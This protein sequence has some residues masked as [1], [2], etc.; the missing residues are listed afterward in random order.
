[1]KKDIL[2][3]F[4]RKNKNYIWMLLV[5][6]L[7]IVMLGVCFDFYY[8]LNDDVVMKN[9]MSGSYSGTPDG[10][11]MQTLYILGWFISLFYKMS[12][13]LPWYGLFLCLCQF[14]SVYLISIRILDL[15][16]ARTARICYYFIFTAF[17]WGMGLSHFVIVQYSI[18]CGS[19]VAVAIF[20]FITTRGGLTGREFVINNIPAIVLVVLAFQ[21]RTEMVLLLSPFIAL[22]GLFR[23]MEEERFFTVENYKKYG[24]VLGIMVA[25]MLLSCVI[26]LPAY[27]N[28]SWSDFRR[29]F[30]NRTIVYDYY[31]EMITDEDKAE[32]LTSVGVSDVQR[33]LLRNYNFGLDNTI[34]TKLMDTV[35]MVAEVEHNAEGNVFGRMVTCFR[36]MCYRLTHK[37][38]LP[39]NIVI[40]LLYLHLLSL[41]IIEYFQRKR[42]RDNLEKIGC[43]EGV[44]IPAAQRFD[45]IK[46]I[47]QIFMAAIIRTIPWMYVLLINRAPERI[48][49]GL[50]LS[51]MGLVLGAL[52]RRI[53]RFNEHNSVIAAIKLGTSFDKRK[54]S[55]K[56]WLHE[57]RAVIFNHFSLLV[58]V[59]FMI[60]AVPI[61]IKNMR[62]LN[63][64][65]EKTQEVS[66]ALKEY[67]D[68]HPQYF[69]FEDVYSTVS[70]S[71][72]MFKGVDNT[73]ANYDIMG[74]WICKS[75]LYQDKLRRYGLKNTADGLLQNNAF[76]VISNEQNTDGFKWLTD[77]YNGI[78]QPVTV[79]WVEEITDGYSVYKVKE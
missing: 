53:I 77:Y 2:I 28:S 79:E 38:D 22:A 37:A 76:L 40:V 5:L 33:E 42:Q 11:N 32:L 25:G 7:N 39:Y 17:C 43:Y 71:E 21:L 58:L 26:D 54:V 9:I 36:D 51:E 4:Y 67:Y 30:D 70:F 52:I 55:V 61:S 1:M 72:K 64:Y 74:G 44:S 66:L 50:Y 60:V 41:N 15:L 8:D 56:E 19:M 35:V 45:R 29:F 73:L 20:W 57:Y 75:P 16:K 65:R 78:G 6:I 47:L 63:E 13:G 34:N 59:V 48:T 18:A 3:A 46:Y 62:A 27:G 23:W 69:Y 31:P 49:I 68:E 12:R 10:H 14:G 24:A